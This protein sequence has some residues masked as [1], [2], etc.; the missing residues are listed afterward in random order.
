MGL[1]YLGNTVPFSTVFWVCA[2]HASARISVRWVIIWPC[3]FTHDTTGQL[4]LPP[5]PTT[6]LMTMVNPPG[7]SFFLFTNFYQFLDDNNDD[8][9]NWHQH[10]HYHHLQHYLHHYHC[11][12]NHNLHHL[13]MSDVTTTTLTCPNVDTTCPTIC[14]EGHKFFLLSFCQL[15]NLF[16]ILDS[17]LIPLQKLQT[18]NNSHEGGPNDG[19][20]SFGP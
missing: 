2:G 13:D 17:C 10:H 3:W 6:T 5:S 16:F 19:K 12:H 7:G 9:S 1:P 18:H 14:N 11:H 20:L 8:D 15:I 4:G